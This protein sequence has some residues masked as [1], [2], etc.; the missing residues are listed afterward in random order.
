[1]AVSSGWGGPCLV[2]NVRM[3]SYAAEYPF[4]V[5]VNK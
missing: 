2:F 4:F 1:M 5:F 3:V